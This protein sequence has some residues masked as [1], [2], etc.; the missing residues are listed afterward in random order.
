MRVA[1]VSSYGGLGGAELTFAVF[2]DHA[3]AHIER[4]VHLLSDGPLRQ[5]LERQGLD[6]TVSRCDGR[7]NARMLFEFSR[8]FR[9][10]LARGEHDVV[11]AV[12]QKAALLTAFACRTRRTPLVW[13]KVDFSWDRL[14][15]RPLAGAASGVI[16]VSDAVADS[17]GSMRSRRPVTIV[18][19]PVSLG[20]P[21]P[22]PDTPAIGTLARLV[23]YKGHHLIIRAAA[24]LS[25][26][27]PEL[28]VVLAGDPAPQYPTYPAELLAEARRLGL[29]DRLD[30]PGFIPAAEALGRLSVF[31]N[32]T[33][34]DS[35]GF[36]FEGLSG[37]ML[38]ASLAGL[39][40]VATAGGGTAEGLISGETGTLVPA[41][42]PE[43]IADAIR[44][45]LS[46]RALAEHTGARG[47]ELVKSRFAP[48]VVS[49]RLWSAIAQA[50]TGTSSS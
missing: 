12:G 29:A 32:A 34:R 11:W 43:A 46:D 36:G 42:D 38:E 33:H 15:A 17:M 35:E 45:Y 47:R 7:P 8:S 28:R 1:C 48:P 5:R 23:P 25:G 16:A 18:G 40:V 26:E 49:S 20:E 2:L 3:P 27:F 41:P 19:P 4:D 10:V 31:V 13:H 37:A 30:L 14:L 24:I 22:R 50:G 39:P 6:V 44:P 21:V 9:G